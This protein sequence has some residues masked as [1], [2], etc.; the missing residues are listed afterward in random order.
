MWAFRDP[1]GCG[2]YMFGSLS[3][4]FFSSSLLLFLL[5]YCPGTLGVNR[6]VRWDVGYVSGLVVRL[7]G[8]WLSACRAPDPQWVGSL[9]GCS[10]LWA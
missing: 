1:L 3:L 7:T 10:R 2:H 5:F 8:R 4:S 9:V 6:F